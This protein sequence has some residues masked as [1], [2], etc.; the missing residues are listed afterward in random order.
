MVSRRSIIKRIRLKHEKYIPSEIE[1][2]VRLKFEK[3]PLSEIIRHHKKIFR[4][5]PIRGKRCEESYKYLLIDNLTEHY[6]I[7]IKIHIINK[8]TLQNVL[9]NRD[10]YKEA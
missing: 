10:Q 2:S 1:E 4:T 5:L 3:E 7:E 9:T 8:Y 6:V